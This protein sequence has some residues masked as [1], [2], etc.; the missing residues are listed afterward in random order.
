MTENPQELKKRAVAMLT[1]CRDYD[2]DCLLEELDPRLL[3]YYDDLLEHSGTEPDDPDDW[4]NLYELLAALKL[5]RILR[6][7]PVDI[8]KVHQV[9]RL[10][11]GAWSVVDGIWRY[12]SGG[13]LL[14]GTRGA[15]HYRW[16]PFQVF[17]L[18]AMYGAQAWIDTEVPNG[19]RELL[20][21]EREGDGGTIEDLRRLCTDFT[22]FAPRKTDKTGLSAYNN[23]LYFML[24][25]DDAEIYC[26]AN[27]QTQSKLL[28]D[29]TQMLIRQMDSQGRRIRFTATTTNWKPGQIR[30]AQLWALSAGG[31][32][33]DG[34]FAQL[35]CADEFGSAAYVNEKS[36]M[37]ALVNVVLSSMGPRREPMMFTSTTAGT[38]Q[39]GPFIDKLNGM[40][41]E[42][43]KELDVAAEPR[44]T[45]PD[46]RLRSPQDR[47]MILP[48]MP[49]EWQMDEEYLLTSKA[50]RKKVNPALGV[51]VQNSFYEQSV[52]D[53]RL[54]PLKKVETLTKLFNV[55]QTGKVKDWIKPDEIR[56]L[57]GE[58][59]QADGRPGPRRIDDCRAEDDWVVF[60][61][62]DFS[63]GDDW[64]GNGYLAFNRRTQEFFADTDLWM[65]EE[66]VNK[67]T[68]RELFLLWAK[69]G[70][71]HIVPGATFS[72]DVVVGRIV[73]LVSQGV[74]IWRIGYDP[75]NAKIVVNAI[76][77]WVHDL[78][79]DPRQFIVP[80][81]QNFATYNGPV[82]EFDYMIHR[83]SIG[84]DGRTVHQPMIHFAPTPVLPFQF[85][86]CQLA[87]SA[88]GMQNY[89]PVKAS[90]VA[91]KV[92][93]V[94]MI[95]SAL[96]LFDQV[97]G[98]ARPQ[99]E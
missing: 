90:G 74:D 5:L 9:I 22:F 85:G 29:R 46:G 8:E 84:F 86:N 18:A 94:Q 70:W 3:D 36:D 31:K 30:S 55:Y 38:I 4:H 81:R 89:K 42:L 40:K 41:Q 28:Y 21:T 16:M 19:S 50:V 11:E 67:S 23:F 47:W 58:W 76:A 73:Q 88:D 24:E 15:T 68:L 98:S 87:E 26:C 93:S 71:L 72:P 77:A 96:W 57:Q 12:E 35:C 92:D 78:G 80:V 48:L 6:T 32:T 44:R 66:A 25:D 39:Q 91:N 82:N 56:N 59:T 14:P 1:Q 49:D 37:G 53:S 63:K 7:Y 13:L 45:E 17:V 27:S 99:D 62:C 43:L 65:S 79:K 61:G 83:S 2:T 60:V 10:R 69:E 33:K 51:I 97:D 95:L 20:P 34:L 52:A 64:N 75:F 54:D